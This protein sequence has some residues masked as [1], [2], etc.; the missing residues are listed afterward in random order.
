VNNLSLDDLINSI[1][2]AKPKFPNVRMI[3]IDGPAGAGK[4]TL[5]KRIKSNLQEQS[6]LKTAIVHMD[7]LYDGWENALTVQLTKTLINQI[8]VP[9]SL[10]KNFSYRK[11]NWL[12]GSFGD[13]SE[14][15]SP[16]ILILEG[17]GSGQKATRRYLD[18]LI[19]IDIDAE[20][21]L[22]R[23]LQR[24]GDYLENEMRVWQMR[25]ISH[26]SKEN[27]RDSATIRINGSFFI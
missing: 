21:G 2:S 11:Y 25:E 7:D 1:L 20:T 24:D 22:Q 27:T 26:F 17:V 23:V 16:E 15:D 8:L 18:Q 9:V 5:A 4:S 10:A 3:A 13:F 14:E 12:S 6:G 19:W